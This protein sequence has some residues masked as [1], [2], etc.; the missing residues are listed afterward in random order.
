MID[1][2]LA[3]LYALRRAQGTLITAWGYNYNN[4]LNRVLARYKKYGKL[5]RQDICN[6]EVLYEK[7]QEI[8]KQAREAKKKNDTL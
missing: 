7:Y 3:K 5:V 2:P 6:I 8:L 1:T 4:L